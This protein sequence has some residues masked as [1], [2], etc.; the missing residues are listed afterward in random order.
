MKVSEIIQK[1]IEVLN[2]AEW[3]KNGWGARDANGQVLNCCAGGALN[4]AR[5][6]NPAS[7][8][9]DLDLHAA[10]AACE[11]VINPYSVEGCTNLVA[12]NDQ[13]ETTRED[14]LSVMKT[15]LAHVLKQEAQDNGFADAEF[16]VD[17][18]HYSD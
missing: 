16:T 12:W 17:C 9:Q 5:F 13:A 11:A 14:V 8:Q 10:Y 15:A 18:C 4:W 6:G 7:Y 2:T 1:A 3:R